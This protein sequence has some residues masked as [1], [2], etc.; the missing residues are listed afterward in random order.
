MWCSKENDG[1]PG[2][3]KSLK[4]F[5]LWLICYILLQ[6]ELPRQPTSSCKPSLKPTSQIHASWSLIFQ[7]HLAISGHG[8]FNLFT[9]PLPKRTH[10]ETRLSL[11]IHPTDSPREQTHLWNHIANR[12]TSWTH[13]INRPSSQRDPPHKWTPP[14]KWNHLVI[15]FTHASRSTSKKRP[16][17]QNRP[18]SNIEKYNW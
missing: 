13:F 11:P 17:S 8:G 15:Y 6:D 3:I 4:L 7:T 16:T 2:R 18:T 5:R 14:C 10:I 12:P 9:I 1:P